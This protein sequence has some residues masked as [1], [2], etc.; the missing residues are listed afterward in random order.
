MI[1]ILRLMRAQ[2]FC[3]ELATQELCILKHCIIMSARPEK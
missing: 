3:L 1:F 2:M